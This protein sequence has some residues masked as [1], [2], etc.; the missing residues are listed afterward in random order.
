MAY[1]GLVDGMQSEIKPRDP[2]DIAA[3]LTVP[4]LG[5]Y[6]GAD[7]YIQRDA[8]RRMR[9]ELLKSESGSEIVVFPGVD[10]GFNADYRPS[11][12]AAAADYARRLARDWLTRHGA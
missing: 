10:H 5:L 9:A 6:A 1:Y 3:E 2:V 11:Y 7:E 12:D 8:L 4:V